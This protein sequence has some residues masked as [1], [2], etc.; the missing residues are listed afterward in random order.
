MT[1]PLARH[2]SGRL[3]FQ[4]PADDLDV[5][6]MLAAGDGWQPAPPAGLG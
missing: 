6:V 1:V 3:L 5:E 2:A 4:L